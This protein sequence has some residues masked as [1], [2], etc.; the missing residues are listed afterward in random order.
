MELDGCEFVMCCI[1]AGTNSLEVILIR[2]FNKSPTKMTHPGY[3]AA[4]A[5]PSNWYSHCNY[6]YTRKITYR[7]GNKFSGDSAPGIGISPKERCRLLE[8]IF[9]LIDF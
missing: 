2:T 5:T 3:A 9:D 6:A 8:G 7:E 4:Q 1:R